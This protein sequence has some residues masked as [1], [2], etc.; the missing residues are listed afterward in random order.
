MRLRTLRTIIF[1][2]NITKTSKK[3]ENAAC[4]TGAAYKIYVNLVKY[5][6]GAESQKKR[7]SDL[8][9]LNLAETVGFEP[10]CPERQTHFECAPL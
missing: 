5:Q 8:H 1:S 10:T 9:S 4:H 7:G 2:T 6:N 3:V